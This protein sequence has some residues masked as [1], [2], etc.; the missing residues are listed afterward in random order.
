MIEELKL[1]FPEFDHLEESPLRFNEQTIAW[2]VTAFDKGSQPFGTGFSKDRTSAQ[3]IAIAE[4]IER[5][6]LENLRESSEGEKW[7]L[8]SNPTSCGFAVGYDNLN[9]KIR[10]IGEAIERWAL[11]QW[12]DSNCPLDV[13]EVAVWPEES[14][15]FLKDFNAIKVFKKSFLF[16]LEEQLIPYE[17]CLIVAFKAE[18]AFMGSA[19]RNDLV[20]AQAHAL[21]EAHRHLI[22]ST[23]ERN[24]KLFPYNRIKFFSANGKMANEILNTKRISKWP[25]PEIEFQKNQQE[26]LF[27]IT[28][29]IIKDWTPWEQGLISRMLY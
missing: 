11:S 26:N 15:A 22:I 27:S 20:S 17:L 3:K 4:F 21:V 16:Q 5:R 6:F 13:I 12:Y 25:N 1:S 19:V 9:T 14:A 29:T 24:F 2:Q 23:Q 8:N 10:S 28:R 18:G 7:K